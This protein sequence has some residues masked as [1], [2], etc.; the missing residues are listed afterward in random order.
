MHNSYFQIASLEDAL[1]NKNTPMKQKTRIAKS[2][3]KN[4]GKKPNQDFQE[5]LP[6]GIDSAQSYEDWVDKVMVNKLESNSFD[7]Q[8][9]DSMNQT[10]LPDFFYPGHR[11]LYSGNVISRTRSESATT[12]D[13][14][15]FDI[16]TI[17]S[18]SDNGYVGGNVDV[19][20]IK[21]AQS[22]IP[23]YVDRKTATIIIIIEVCRF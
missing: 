14:D 7:R 12:D 11:K 21:K 22:R 3:N 5:L 8:P 9:E 13:S 15:E 23:Q 1:A 4:L 16:A 17:D 6:N 19:L 10:H 20:M 2:P 18:S